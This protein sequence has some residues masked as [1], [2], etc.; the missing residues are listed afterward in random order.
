[1]FDLHVD[2]TFGVNCYMNKTLKLTKTGVLIAL[3]DVEVYRVNK[4]SRE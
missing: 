4:E 3:K 1:M 2:R